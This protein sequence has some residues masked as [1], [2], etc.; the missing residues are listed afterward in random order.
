[1]SGQGG[2]NTTFRVACKLADAGLSE[3]QVL[4]ELIAWNED[5]CAVPKWSETELA[6]KAKS[7]I[8]ITAKI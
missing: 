8:T 4:A 2:H 7:A 1:M 3:E 5:G 6:H